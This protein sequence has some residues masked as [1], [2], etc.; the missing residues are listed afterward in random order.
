MTYE[1]MVQLIV[2]SNG[3][4]EIRGESVAPTMDYT[5]LGHRKLHKVSILGHALPAR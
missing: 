3:M 1:V 5:Y 2:G 4:S